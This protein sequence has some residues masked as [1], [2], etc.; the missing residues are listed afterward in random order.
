MRFLDL[1]RMDDAMLCVEFKT[2]DRIKARPNSPW[3]IGWQVERSEPGVNAGKTKRRVLP[4]V[5][6]PEPL[7]NRVLHIYSGANLPPPANRSVS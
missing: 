2:E 7:S 5:Y 1:P 3:N 4:N 6:S